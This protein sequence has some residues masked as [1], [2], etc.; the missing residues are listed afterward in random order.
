MKEN[1]VIL[2]KGQKHFHVKTPRKEDNF[3]IFRQRDMRARL[4]VSQIYYMILFRLRTT[5]PDTHP[6]ISRLVRS[7][8]NGHRKAEICSFHSFEL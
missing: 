7:L 4:R 1:K 3:S 2:G 6:N 5:R 8:S